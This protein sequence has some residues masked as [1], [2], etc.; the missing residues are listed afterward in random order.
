[1][2]ALGSFSRF[3][4]VRIIEPADHRQDAVF[5]SGVH[6]VRQG[7]EKLSHGSVLHGGVSGKAGN[8]VISGG[9]R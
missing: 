2:S 7:I 3:L 4:G 9:F 1:M 8:S 5:K 6:L